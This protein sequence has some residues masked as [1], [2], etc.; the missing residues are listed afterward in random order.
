M[1]S[2]QKDGTSYQ[3]SKPKP[4][5]NNCGFFGTAGTMNLCSKCYRDFQISKPLPLKPPWRNHST[6][7]PLPHLIK[8]RNRTLQRNPENTF[9]NDSSKNNISS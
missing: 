4:C 7:D 5:A 2:H 6:L 8:R 1:S 3:L 9:H